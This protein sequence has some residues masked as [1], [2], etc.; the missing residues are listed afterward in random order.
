LPPKTAAAPRTPTSSPASLSAG[1]RQRVGISAPPRSRRRSSTQP[2]CSSTARGQ[3]SVCE[4]GRCGDGDS[5]ATRAFAAGAGLAAHAKRSRR[6]PPR[7]RLALASAHLLFVG[8]AA[9]QPPAIARGQVDGISFRQER[10]LMMTR[11]GI[12]DDAA[13]ARAVTA[14]SRRSSRRVTERT[15]PLQQRAPCGPPDPLAEIV[16]RDRTES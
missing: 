12:H 4:H 9:P 7:L 8:G 2:T 14:S 6:R 1:M 3:R 16:S 10:A 5:G 13:R 11:P 15:S